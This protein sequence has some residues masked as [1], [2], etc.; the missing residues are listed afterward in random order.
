MHTWPL[1]VEDESQVLQM[2]SAK[3]SQLCKQ[4]VSYYCKDLGT[5]FCVFCFVSLHIS[6]VIFTRRNH[7]MYTLS[8][9][10]CL[11]EEVLVD[12]STHKNKPLDRQTNR[13]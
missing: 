8:Q 12:S 13:L 4:R 10:A 2:W 3:A 9:A 1:A 7:L 11:R 6:F 5:R